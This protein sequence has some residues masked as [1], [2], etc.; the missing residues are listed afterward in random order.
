VNTDRGKLI[1]GKDKGKR[2][3]PEYREEKRS[4]VRERKAT[5]HEE[6]EDAEIDDGDEPAG[7]TP[8]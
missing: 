2:F 6:P 8:W 4:E 5:C 3:Y 7:V 1:C